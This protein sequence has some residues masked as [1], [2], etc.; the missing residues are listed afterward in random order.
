[1]TVRKTGLVLSGDPETRRRLRLGMSSQYS[2]YEA[3]DKETLTTSLTFLKPQLI[4]V[5]GASLGGPDLTD[6]SRTLRRYLVV[7]RSTCTVMLLKQ[8]THANLFTGI[9]TSA[10]RVYTMHSLEA[11][12]ELFRPPRRSEAGHPA[13]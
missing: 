9:E 13:H 7:F 10:G 12:L 1:M 8:P 5:E 2:L 4:V 11:L 3:E 6:I